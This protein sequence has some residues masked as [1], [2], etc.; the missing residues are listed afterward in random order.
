M[1][2]SQREE[3]IERGWEKE[4]EGSSVPIFSPLKFRI[5]RMFPGSVGFYS[6]VS[7]LWEKRGWFLLNLIGAFCIEL[8]VLSVTIF[9][10]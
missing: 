4:R 3:K 5:V 6:Q 2:H 7:V 9:G 10:Q 1:T 8:G